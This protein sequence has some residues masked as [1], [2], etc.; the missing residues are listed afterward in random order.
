MSALLAS[1]SRSVTST[2]PRKVI[3]IAPILTLISALAFSS[4]S[5]SITL[6]P[7]THGMIRSRSRIAAQLY[8]VSLPVAKV[9]LSST[10]RPHF[11][12]DDV[13]HLERPEERR[14]GLDLEVRLLDLR[15]AL[16]A[17]EAEGER[18]RHAVQ[19]EL[20]RPVG[21][22]RAREHVFVDRLFDRRLLFV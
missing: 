21:D 15:P 13:G 5:R 9:W 1:S 20:A 14:E 11:H 19:G 22:R 8:S 4:D 2:V 18:A 10:I 17:V 3:D 12:L 7:S 16:G 6:P